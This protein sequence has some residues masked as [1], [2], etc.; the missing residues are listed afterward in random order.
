VLAL[1]THYGNFEWMSCATDMHTKNKGYAIYSPLKNPY[2]EALAVKTRERWGGELLPARAAIRNSLSKLDEPCIIGFIC[3]QT[4]SRRE[5][6]YFSK[7]LGLTTAVHDRFAHLALQ[8][9]AQVYFIEVRKEKRGYYNLTL[10][11]MPMEQFLPYSQENAHRFTD[12]HIELLEKL[13]LAQP[14]F[15]LWTH[16][17]WKHQPQEGDLFSEK[18]TVVDGAA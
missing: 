10:V 4:P 5:G 8:K 3:D 7:F 2:F 14:E 18:L 17:R 6:L 9:A 12:Y 13:I 1:A 16:K 15:W 11:P